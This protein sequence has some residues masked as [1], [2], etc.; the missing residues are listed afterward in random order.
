M[1]SDK[2]GAVWEVKEQ[3]QHSF[4][5]PEGLIEQHL[6]SSTQTL[7]HLAGLEATF[8]PSGKINPLKSA[9]TVAVDTAT[10]ECGNSRAGGKPIPHRSRRAMR[11]VLK[12]L[13]RTKLARENIEKLTVP[14]NSMHLI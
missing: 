14:E 1:A 2:T 12:K 5:V 3:L 11:S 10:C 7:A 6:N 13:P 4:E 8:G 9:R